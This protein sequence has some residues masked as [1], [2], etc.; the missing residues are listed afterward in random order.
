METRPEMSG[1]IRRTSG[2]GRLYDSSI[3]D[4]IGDTPC[5]RVNGSHRSMSSVS[6]SKPSF[7][8]RRAP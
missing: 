7:S 1:S 5:V 6:T 2:R 8:T 4:T 3:V